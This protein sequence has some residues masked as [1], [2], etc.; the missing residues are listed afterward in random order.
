MSATRS[1]TSPATISQSPALVG[2]IRSTTSR[3][4]ACETC[5]SLVASRE[6]RGM[7]RNLTGAPEGQLLEALTGPGA[8]AVP[9]RADAITVGAT[10]LSRQ[11]LLAA[12]AA[13]ADR[14]R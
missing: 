2:R 11:E 8:T 13:V 14:V 9:D 7:S 6:G 1:A 4:P 12:A 3:L 10:R 5:R